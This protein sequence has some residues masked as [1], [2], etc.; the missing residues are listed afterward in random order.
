M[1]GLAEQ[2]E[3]MSDVI[4]KEMDEGR[5]RDMF[6]QPDATENGRRIKRIRGY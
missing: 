1:P 3:G 5:K 2:S 6:L 4:S